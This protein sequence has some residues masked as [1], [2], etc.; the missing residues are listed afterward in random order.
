MVID[1]IF[2]DM[3]V[4]SLYRPDMMRFGGVPIRVHTPPIPEA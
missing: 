1:K 3:P 4:L 2:I